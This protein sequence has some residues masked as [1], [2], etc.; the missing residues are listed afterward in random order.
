MAYLHHYIMP[1]AN[2]GNIQSPPQT[3]APK[4]LSVKPQN[5]GAQYTLGLME[6]TRNVQYRASAS[7]SHAGRFSNETV[8]DQVVK[9]K[10]Y[11][12]TVSKE[13]GS[14]TP[15]DMIRRN[16]ATRV[17]S[18]RVF[19]LDD[20]ELKDCMSG[21]QVEDFRPASEVN[22]AQ[23]K[24]AERE[25]RAN[26][27]RNKIDF[28][29]REAGLM[30]LLHPFVEKVHFS[31]WAFDEQI[32]P[33]HLVDSNMLEF[34]TQIVF[35]RSLQ[36]FYNHMNHKHRM[37]RDEAVEAISEFNVANFTD[38]F[39]RWKISPDRAINS[40]TRYLILNAL[41]HAQ[42]SRDLKAKITLHT[43][44]REAMTICL[45]TN[46]FQHLCEPRP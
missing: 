22:Y 12:A 36:D 1:A 40:S 16:L 4:V 5:M 26:W 28:D 27:I 24:P 44:L 46:C 32:L 41:T 33:T 39:I 29:P 35:R 45:G 8:S 30:D 21:F 31:D 13:L 6:S 15:A 19:D 43:T 34:Y 38:F 42:A 25:Y 3:L 7:A 11:T 2:N 10:T 14:A 9:K 23:L 20:D 18:A 17:R 37:T